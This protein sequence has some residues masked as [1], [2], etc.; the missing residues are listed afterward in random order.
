M[1]YHS[2]TPFGR[3]PVTAG[4]IKTVE[5]ARRSPPIPRTDKWGLFR[6]L[7]TARDAFGV[8]DRDLTVLNALLS[9]LPGK[10]LDEAEQMTV[11]PSNRTLA[12]RAHGMAEST[13]RRHVAALIKAGLIVRR[14]SPNGKRYVRRNQSGDITQAY[15]FDL[16]PLLVRAAEISDAC[17]AAE[18]AATRRQELREL[19]A[20][21]KRD[22][23]KLAEFG[24]AEGLDGNWDEIFDR[25]ALLQRR[26]RRKLDLTLLEMLHQDVENLLIKIQH[27]FSETQEMSGYDSQNERHIQS[28]KPNT[29]ESEQTHEMENV[30]SNSHDQNTQD[31]KPTAELKIPLSLVLKACPDIHPYARDP[32][33]HWNGLYDVA[34]MVRGM[35]GI[36]NSTWSD[37]T[38]A[39]GPDCAA[40]VVAGMLQ[41]IDEIKNPGGYLRSLT[42]KAALGK[43]SPGPMVMSLLN[44]DGLAKS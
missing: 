32:I 33:R 36:N 38:R 29:L 3:R 28:S 21:K 11:F 8:S 44:R 4:L 40:T 2:T 35:M 23:F 13:L 27:M 6:Q 25:L 37:A 41:R 12:E 31:Q 16:R 20:L 24:R 17:R 34:Q 5:A 18:D 1:T 10:A 7:C 14:D 19:I 22:A 9:F 42:Q 15:G 43:F 39:M 26:G 30:A